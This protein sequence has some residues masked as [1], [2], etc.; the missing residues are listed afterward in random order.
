MN[1]SYRNGHGINTGLIENLDR[2]AAGISINSA[3]PQVEC[4]VVFA[5][6][7]FPGRVKL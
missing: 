4:S 3:V 2:Q 6:S 1:G 5:D 7:G